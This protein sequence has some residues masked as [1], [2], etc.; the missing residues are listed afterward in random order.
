MF[1]GVAGSPVAGRRMVRIIMKIAAIINWLLISRFGVRFPGGP[2]LFHYRSIGSSSGLNFEE[3]RQS[4]WKQIGSKCCT[5][6]KS[7]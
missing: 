6:K 5:F 3:L 2:F 7:V 4:S 1:Q